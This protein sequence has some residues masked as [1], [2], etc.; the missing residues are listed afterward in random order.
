MMHSPQELKASGNPKHKKA[1]GKH[2]ALEK[3]MTRCEFFDDVGKGKKK[4]KGTL[5]QCL[6]V[7]A[8]KH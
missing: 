8:L 5:F 4:R 6:V 1:V 7:L 3:L 2:E